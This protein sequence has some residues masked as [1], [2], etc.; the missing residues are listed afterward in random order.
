MSL[1]DMP[2]PEG[3]HVTWE[4]QDSPSS[5]SRQLPPLAATATASAEPQ[6]I[7]RIRAMPAWAWILIVL[8]AVTLGVIIGVIVRRNNGAVFHPL[9]PR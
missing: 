7:D 2:L 3:R 1:Y 5:P 6:L 8:G 4:D 9:A